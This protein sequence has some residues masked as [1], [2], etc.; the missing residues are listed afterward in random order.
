MESPVSATASELRFAAEQLAQAKCAEDVFGASSAPLLGER[1]R[2]LARQIHPDHFQAHPVLLEIATQALERLI[3]WHKQAQQKITDGTY[4]DAKAPEPKREPT[5]IKIPGDTLSLSGLIRSGDI[6]DVHAGHL[7]KQDRS[8]VVK[9]ARS[10]RD[11]D[12]IDSEAA[13]LRELS[14]HADAKSDRYFPPAPVGKLDVGG[15]RGTILKRHRS[16]VAL[17][18]IAR[19]ATLGLRDMAWMLRRIFEGIGYVH[20]L[21]YVHGSVLPEHLLYH[22]SSHGLRLVDWCYA[23]PLGKKAVAFSGV[24]KDFYPPEVFAKQPLTQVSDIFMAA[25]CAEWMLPDAPHPIQA[26]LAGCRLPSASRRPRD[27][28]DVHEEFGEL[29]EKLIGPP[30]FHELKLSAGDSAT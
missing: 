2:L 17:D 29:L 30:K 9:V 18:Q 12:L 16:H 24:R 3:Y 21:G 23:V 1:F 20:R 28:W 27:A 11:N 6:A 8:V 7:T 26:F 14:Q 22:P 15:R 13:V 25:R 5:L 10:A 19:R 4:G